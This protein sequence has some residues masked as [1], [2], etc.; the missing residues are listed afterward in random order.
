MALT[1]L[2]TEGAAQLGGPEADVWRTF[3]A[4]LWMAYLFLVTGVVLW[5]FF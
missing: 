5:W 3:A 2:E 1:P 4:W